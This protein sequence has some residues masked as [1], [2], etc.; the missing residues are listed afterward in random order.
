MPP[1]P[2]DSKKPHYDVEIVLRDEQT[3]IDV[4]R[5]FGLHLW[6]AQATFRGRSDLSTTGKNG[7]RLGRRRQRI[8][9]CCCELSEVRN[10]LSQMR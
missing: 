6:Q 3:F 4:K 1:C 5:Q 9:M 8:P 2:D 7:R 10:A